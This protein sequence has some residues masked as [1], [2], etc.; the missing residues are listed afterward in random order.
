MRPARRGGGLGPI[1]AAP[2]AV[3]FSSS[4]RRRTSGRRSPRPAGHC[5]RT[6]ASSAP[7]SRIG[8]ARRRSRGF[9]RAWSRRRSN[10]Q[11]WPRRRWVWM[12]AHAP[13][14]RRT[15]APDSASS[16]RTGFT[17]S[18]EGSLKSPTGS[19]LAP[20]PPPPASRGS[21]PRS[22]PRSPKDQRPTPFAIVT[23]GVVITLFVARHNAIAPFDFWASLGV[24]ALVELDWAS[25]R[26]VREPIAPR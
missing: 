19:S 12:C 16:E 1:V 6:D 22:S 23:H 15:T 26:L 14:S 21:R 18:L 5:R 25:F 20:R 2:W 8:C 17:A 13:A 7:G 4:M 24:A 11:R 9:I 3:S 10:P